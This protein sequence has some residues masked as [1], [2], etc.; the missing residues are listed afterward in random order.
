LSAIVPESLTYCTLDSAKEARDTMART[1]YAADCEIQEYL[2][3]EYDMDTYSA[4]QVTE[5]VEADFVRM[6]DQDA[7]FYL[8][9]A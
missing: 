3:A 8:N 7:E 5:I 1:G 6:A 4:L 9:G 2:F